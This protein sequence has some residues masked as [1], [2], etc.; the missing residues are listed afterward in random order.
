MESPELD[1]L[2]ALDIGTP[3]SPL[4]A[5][6]LMLD[7]LRQPHSDL[8]PHVSAPVRHLLYQPA[9]D[10]VGEAGG[11]GEGPPAGGAEADLLPAALAN[12]VTRG[13][14]GD[15]ECPGDQQTHWALQTGL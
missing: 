1:L 6:L 7:D 2:A 15:W 3:H 8:A 11:G 13:T 14:G 9:H 5:H 10:A 4:G 12:D